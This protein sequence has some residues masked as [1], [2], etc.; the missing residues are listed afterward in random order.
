LSRIAVSR[1]PTAEPLPDVF[2]PLREAGIR[3]RRGTV[4][5]FAGTPGSMKTF[6]VLYMLARMGL[7]T[8]FFSADTDSKTITKRAAAMLT[9]DTQDSVE[10]SLRTDGGASFYADELE[11]LSMIRWVFESDPTYRDL[12]LETMAF[13]EAHGRY[14]EVIVVDNLMNVVGQNEDE[15]GSMRDTTKAF[16]RLVRFTDAALF[17]LHHM[18]ERRTDNTSPAPR[19]DLQGKVSQ[20]PETILSL[21]F[22]GTSE[23]KVA[24]VKNRFGPADAT[25]RTHVVSL[26][27]NP[28]TGQ[29]YSSNYNRANGVPA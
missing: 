5:M 8:L 15:W 19:S 2:T 16:K 1:S 4:T 10:A 11:R 29:F 6:M 3:P 22:D 23:L 9:G 26:W 12:E 20:L 14:P 28:S 13:A 18:A 25:A 17:V 21:A 7:P 27:V 24:P